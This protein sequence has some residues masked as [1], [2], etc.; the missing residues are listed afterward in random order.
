MQDQGLKTK[1]E[2]SILVRK[3]FLPNHKER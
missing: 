2:Y 1:K 3:M